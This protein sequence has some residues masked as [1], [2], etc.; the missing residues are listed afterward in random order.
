MKS[1]SRMGR[2]KHPVL[3]LPT[4]DEAWR[5]FITDCVTADFAVG[6]TMSRETLLQ[7]GV[8][9]GTHLGSTHEIGCLHA[10]KLFDFVSPGIFR[11]EVWSSAKERA[12]AEHVKAVQVVER[13]RQ[14]TRAAE[15]QARLE[16]QKSP[17]GIAHRQREAVE[18]KRLWA[19]ADQWR[20]EDALRRFMN[21]TPS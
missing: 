11:D 14:A 18:A 4:R 9:V 15:K 3:T 8:R 7:L 13:E 1:F 12:W 6:T 10:A 16:W 2:P 21:S 17:E 20:R 5:D 19:Q